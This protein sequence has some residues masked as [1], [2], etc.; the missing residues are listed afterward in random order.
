MAAGHLAELFR[1]QV[2]AHRD[3]ELLVGA[4]Q[5]W[6]YGQV[7]ERAEALATSL[8][9]LGLRA[10][11]RLAIDLPNWP[12]WV[13]TLLAGARLG[14]TVV[15]L[16]PGLGYH[17]LKYQLRHSEVGAAVVAERYGDTDFL[18]L[19][20]ELLPELPEL[21][22]LATVGP[23]DLW[24]DDRIFQFEDLVAKGRHRAAPVPPASALEPATSPLAIVYTSGTMGKP[25]GVVLSHRSIVESGRAVAESLG[26]TSDDRILA[27]VPFFTVFGVGIIVGTIA[28]GGTLVLQERF[29]AR[30]AIELIERERATVMHGVPTMYQLVMRDP[31]FTPARVKSLRTGLV[32]GGLVTPELIAR[33]RAWCDAEIAYGLT[34]TGPAV[35][36]TRRS[37]PPEKRANTVG[38]PLPGVECRVVDV[39]TGALHGLEAVG[40]LAVKSDLLML[41][42]HRMPGETARSLTPE[43]YFLTGD[44]AMI[45]EDGFLQVV[46]RRKELIIRGGASVTPREVEDVL[47]TYP[48]VE[49]ACVVG[50]PN[51]V[52]GELVCACVVP[53]EGAIVTGDELKE[54]CREH[55]ADHKVPDLVRFFDSFPMTGSGKVK[56][57]ELSRVVGLELSAT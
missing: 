17:E 48:A 34:E 15:P 44:L 39:A 40:E 24:Y 31:A 26:V 42:Y 19:F 27:C 41:G 30:E 8:A 57:R 36:L 9:D 38:R 53:V 50:V 7:D 23:E 43:G 3:R 35:S 49:E 46:G 5:R 51:E 21:S 11:D 16:D 32:A 28:A 37:D 4:G 47:R 22:F 18:E 33:V 52:F 10:G 20:E 1:A 54:F 45:D 2:Q 12:E 13:V 14:L 56:R 29:N 55:L 6:T 25:K